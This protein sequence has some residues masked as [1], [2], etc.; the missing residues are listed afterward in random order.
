MGLIHLSCSTVWKQEISKIRYYKSSQITFVNSSPLVVS[1]GYD[2]ISI[3][4]PNSKD[5]KSGKEKGKIDWISEPHGLAIKI[6]N[7]FP[8]TFN[9]KVG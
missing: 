9:H 8:K 5:K 1:R 7:D 4:R 3:K 2:Q 6:S